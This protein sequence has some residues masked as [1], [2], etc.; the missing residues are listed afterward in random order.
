MPTPK[1]PPLSASERQTPTPWPKNVYLNDEAEL[2]A[3]IA[4]HA[5]ALYINRE[6]ASELM[7]TLTRC[8]ASLVARMGDVRRSRSL[9][10]ADTLFEPEGRKRLWDALTQWGVG[11]GGTGG[12]YGGTD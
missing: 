6:E 8:Q 1:Q 9:P 10:D 12:N 5:C 3:F 4:Q 11:S 2:K 7:Q